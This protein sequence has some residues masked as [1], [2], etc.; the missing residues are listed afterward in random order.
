MTE[1]QNERFGMLIDSIDNLKAAAETP[2]PAK[3][4]L[5]HINAILPELSA[6]FK[7]LFIEITGE[8]PWE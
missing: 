6:E 7:K 2:L 5:E 3:I 4:H 8:N 1:E